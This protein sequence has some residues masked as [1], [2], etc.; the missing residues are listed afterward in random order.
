MKKWSEIQEATLYN[1]FMTLTDVN[2]EVNDYLSKMIYYANDCLSVIAN[3]IR[4]NV[5]KIVLEYKGDFNPEIEHNVKTEKY[6]YY[7][8]KSSCAFDG[9]TLNSGDYIYSDGVN[10]II[11]RKNFIF[12][13]PED[14]ISYSDISCTFD[15]NEFTKDMFAKFEENC[16]KIYIGTDKLLLPKE[17]TYNLYYYALYGIIPNNLPFSSEGIDRDLT[18]DYYEDGVLTFTGIPQSVLNV[19]PTYI[20]SKLCAQDDPQRSA[21]LR[22]EFEIA[23]NRLDSTNFYNLEGF[24]SKGGWV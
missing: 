16:E 24:V 18:K 9:E 10:W 19:L 6:N 21:I 2:E 22:N 12:Q 14:F 20:A 13:F 3:D 8:V 15:P 17:G 23:A 11:S 4:P 1:L 5:R 7:S